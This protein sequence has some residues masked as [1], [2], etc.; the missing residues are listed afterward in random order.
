LNDNCHFRSYQA[1]GYFSAVT[2]TLAGLARS[3][4]GATIDINAGHT[5]FKY[6]WKNPEIQTRPMKLVD[7][8]ANDYWS[9]KENYRVTPG[10]A[11]REIIN[12]LRLIH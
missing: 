1:G 11:P 12:Q 3:R 9:Q 5:S 8:M 4:T 10:V 2:L 6:L 7:W